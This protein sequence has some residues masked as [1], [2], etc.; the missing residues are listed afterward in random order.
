MIEVDSSSIAQKICKP[1]GRLIGPKFGKDV[2]FI[3][4]EAKAGNFE[5]V[6]ENTVKVGDFTLE[7]DEFEMAFVTEGDSDNIESGFGMVI[8]MDLEITPELETE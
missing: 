3:I 1:N 7:G 8:A 5:E 4:S 6:D 2:K